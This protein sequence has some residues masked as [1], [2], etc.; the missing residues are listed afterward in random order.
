MKKS[1]IKIISVLL[2]FFSIFTIN[3]VSNADVSSMISS[4]TPNTDT[5]A[6]SK[7]NTVGQNIVGIIQVVGIAVAVGMLLFLGMK[8]VKAAPDENV[9]FKQSSVIYIV[10]AV[11]LFAAVNIVKLI[12]TMATEVVPAG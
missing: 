11:V 9:I 2:I 12:Y 6:A 3:I 5:Q 7:V 10:G 1:M 4:F 8:Y